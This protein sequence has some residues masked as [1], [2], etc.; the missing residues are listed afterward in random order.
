[1]NSLKHTYKPGEAGKIKISFI[2]DDENNYVFSVKDYGVGIPDNID[3]QRMNSPGMQLVINITTQ[4]HGTIKHYNDQGTE[5][6]IS[7][8]ADNKKE[9]N[10][11]WL[12][13]K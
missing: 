3:F 1:M 8:P 13:A 11:K 6:V 9:E 2:K 10:Q 7:F 12:T 4:L 5:F